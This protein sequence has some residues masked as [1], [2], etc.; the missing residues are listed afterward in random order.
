MAD[1]QKLLG[2]MLSTGLSGRG[3][4]GAGLASSLGGGGGPNFKQVAG[5]AGLAYMAYKAF[6]ERAAN[7]RQ[8]GQGN[9][10]T[11]PASTGGSGTTEPSLSERLSS[12]LRPPPALPPVAE[13][14]A[15]AAASSL[16]DARAM[17][18]IRAMIAAANAD[19]KI[20]DTERRNIMSRLDSAGAGNEERRIVEQELANPQSMDALVRAVNDPETAE[21][22]FMASLIAVDGDNPSEQHYLQYLATRLNIQPQ[23][24]QELRAAVQG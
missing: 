12:I 1:L 23:R 7:Q 22:V 2:T 8:A 18:L 24:M 3:S 5:M 16:G 6:Q 19:G 10:G 9:A 17:L 14:A 20:D 13:Q 11:V 4:R 15:A 21:Q